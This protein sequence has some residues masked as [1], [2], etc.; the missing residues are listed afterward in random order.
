MPD[1]NVFYNIPPHLSYACRYWVPHRVEVP[2]VNLRSELYEDVDKFIQ[3]KGIFW[4]EA[5]SLLD[6][7]EIAE[8]QMWQLTQWRGVSAAP[9]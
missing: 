9:F 3:T 7:I 4:V 1:I 5:L 8:R 6:V 2:R